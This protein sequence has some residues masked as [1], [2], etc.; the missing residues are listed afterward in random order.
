MFLLHAHLTMVSSS[1]MQELGHCCI[2]S[3]F[4]KMLTFLLEKGINVEF[5]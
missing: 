1:F 5:S 3:R 2:F 4:I